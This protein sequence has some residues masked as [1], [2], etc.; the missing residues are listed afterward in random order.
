MRSLRWA[1]AL[2]LIGLVGGCGGSPPSSTPTPA[3]PAAPAAAAPAA[4]PKEPEFKQ[5][6][7]PI[8][9]EAKG[10]RDPF[11]QPAGAVATKGGLTIASVKLV[12]ILHGREGP[13][14]MVEGPGGL[15][16]ILRPG[17]LIG[18][19]RVVEVGLDSVTFSVTGLPGQPPTRAVLQLKTD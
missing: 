2:G 13:L 18:D 8:S 15:G 10:R 12:G 19:G 16:Y 11:R 14:A 7:P 5:P 6:P 9:Y 17:D 1:A 3:R 4:T